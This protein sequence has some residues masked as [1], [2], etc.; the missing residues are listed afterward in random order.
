M[1]TEDDLPRPKVAMVA[2]PPLDRLG[3]EELQGYI[4]ALR[5]EIGRAEAEIARKKMQLDAAH[6]FFRTP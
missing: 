5:L 2:S 4:A 1:L 3:V 6:R